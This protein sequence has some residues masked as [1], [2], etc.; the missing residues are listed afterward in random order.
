MKQLIIGLVL[1]AMCAVGA[2]AQAET[3]EGMQKSPPGFYGGAVTGAM[4]AWLTLGIIR[5][6][7]D[8]SGLLLLGTLAMHPEWAKEDF[9]LTIVYA[10]KD[11]GCTSNNKVLNF[12]RAQGTATAKKEGT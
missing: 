12:M 4:Y 8:V 5:C 6:E 11:V 3:L 9:A 7:Q 10:M 1:V 2:I